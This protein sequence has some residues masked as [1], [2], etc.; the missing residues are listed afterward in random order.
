[1][2][3]LGEPLCRGCS[4]I[5]PWAKEPTGIKRV[6]EFKVCECRTFCLQFLSR[7]K[8]GSTNDVDDV[9]ALQL[10]LFVRELAVPLL[11]HLG[12]AQKQALSSGATEL[13]SRINTSEAP[14]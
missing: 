4:F 11:Q 2:G 9:M 7:G 6:E 5:W 8:P 13:Q 1:M 10:S 3:F 14:D 12:V